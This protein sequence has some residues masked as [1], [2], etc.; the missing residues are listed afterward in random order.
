[1]SHWRKPPGRDR[2]SA[3][4]VVATLSGIALICVIVLFTRLSQ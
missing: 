2:D 3:W 1:M 4:M